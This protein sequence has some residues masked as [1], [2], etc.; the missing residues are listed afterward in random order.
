MLNVYP[1][2]VA[3]LAYFKEL[4]LE[5]GGGEDTD[6]GLAGYVVGNHLSSKAQLCTNRLQISST[7]MQTNLNLALRYIIH[8]TFIFI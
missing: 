6:D 8:D 5:G 2:L 3:Y 1:G 7:F 4:S